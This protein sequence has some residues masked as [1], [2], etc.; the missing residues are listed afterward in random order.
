M[1]LFYVLGAVV[2]IALGVV[3][4]LFYLLNKESD[5]DLKVVPITSP[6]GLLKPV[7]PSM[8]EQEYKAKVEN[9][10]E[11]LRAISEKGVAQAQEAMTMIEKLSKENETLKNFKSQ[12]AAIQNED[13]ALAQKQA[14]QLHQDNGLLQAQL[15]S[16]QEKVRQ[17]QEE[18]VAIRQRM[19]D[20]LASGKETIEQ[21]K[22]EREEALA[23]ARE[24]QEVK[25]QNAA[26]QEE[27][28]ALQLANQKLR[29]QASGLEKI[30]ENYKMQLE[31]KI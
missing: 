23:L 28:K 8:Q 22:K 4:F 13:L 15:V 9:L 20:E 6:E 12:E 11:E 29:A 27:I 17:L 1:S 5:Q 26:L 14:E 19:E 2:L 10:E 3:G 31:Q 18:A 21:F 25:A 24:T 16:S 30:C 7:T